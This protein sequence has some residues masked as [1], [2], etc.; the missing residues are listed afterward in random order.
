MPAAFYEPDGDRFLATELTR[1]PW[2]P[3]AQHAGGRRRPC[4]GGR[5]S[6]CPRRRG[7]PGRPRHLR[8]PALGPDRLGPGS[9]PACCGPGGRVQ[10]VEAVAER[11]QGG[12]PLM[13]AGAWRLRAAPLEIPAEAMVAG[14]PPPGPEQGSEA[15]S[16]RP[17]RSSGITR[18]WS[19]RFVPR[20]LRRAGAGPGLAADAPA[21]RRRRGARAAAAGA[22][23]RRRRQRRQRQ[24][25]LP[26]LSLH[27]RRH[28]RPPGAD[29][30]GGVGS[31][32]TPWTLPQ[33]SGNGTA[34]SVL[35]DEGGRIGRALQTL[36]IA[37]R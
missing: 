13:R 4:W 8:D 31:P 34:E 6:S 32:S 26:A 7:V 24:P 16:S 18:R 5:S 25:R 22:G 9:P 30:G 11:D 37:Q 14:Q 12:E 21:A 33:P 27:Q 36:L 29:A 15:E 23:R 3:G 19:V 28:H 35:S 10:L 1:G 2:D 17:G 20:R